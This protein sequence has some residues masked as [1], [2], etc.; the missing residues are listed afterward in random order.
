MHEVHL[1]LHNQV[2]FD[3]CSVD[4]AGGGKAAGAKASRKL[5]YANCTTD[6][7]GSFRSCSLPSDALLTLQSGVVA[8]Y[9]G[10]NLGKKSPLLVGTGSK[11][12]KSNAPYN[13]VHF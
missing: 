13:D 8:L 1:R 9:L 12:R 2:R 7:K 5:V 10:Y 4:A 6:R 11:V 3:R